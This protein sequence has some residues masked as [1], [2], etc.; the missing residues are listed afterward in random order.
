[1]LTAFLF[2]DED[3]YLRLSYVTQYLN[4]LDFIIIV[5][6]IIISIILVCLFTTPFQI[7]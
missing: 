3:N 7:N 1:M 5:I 2:R 4:D 6:I